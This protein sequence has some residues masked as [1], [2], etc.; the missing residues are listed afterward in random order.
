MKNIKHKKSRVALLGALLI[1]SLTLFITNC[2]KTEVKEVYQDIP[3][4]AMKPNDIDTNCDC[5]APSITQC[6]SNRSCAR[7]FLGGSFSKTFTI[8][9]GDGCALGLTSTVDLCYNW[10]CKLEAKFHNVPTCMSDCLKEDACY[11]LGFTCGSN[12]VANGDDTDVNN[13]PMHIS[14][15]GD[16]HITVTCNG[17]DYN[18]ELQ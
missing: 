14:I 13:N 7:K 3:N 11:I 1:V 18:G 16:P 4:K 17:V 6:G 15:I 10:H 8:V 5:K 12:A 9:W 2:R